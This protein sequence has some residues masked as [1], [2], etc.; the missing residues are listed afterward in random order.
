MNY[1]L[2]SPVS[3]KYQWKALVVTGFNSMAGIG[4]L[5]WLRV[6]TLWQGFVSVLCTRFKFINLKEKTEYYLDS[7]E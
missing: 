2:D 4:R 7:N 1:E 3:A 6:L 5:L